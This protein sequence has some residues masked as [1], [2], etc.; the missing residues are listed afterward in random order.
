MP[1]LHFQFIDY[2]RIIASENSSGNSKKVMK[3]NFTIQLQVE[4]QKVNSKKYTKI[5]KKNCFLEKSIIVWKIDQ[6]PAYILIDIR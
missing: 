5:W 6:V 4:V 3:S 1:I 2:C